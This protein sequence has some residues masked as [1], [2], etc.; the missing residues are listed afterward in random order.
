MDRSLKAALLLNASFE[1]RAGR[2][3]DRWIR[4]GRDPGDLMAFSGDWTDLGLPR[5]AGETLARGVARGWAE[6]ELQRCLRLGVRLLPWGD[7]GLPEGLADLPDPPGVLYLW[8]EG[9][10]PPEDRA[11]GAVGTRRATAYG[12]R[13]AR[14]LGERAAETGMWLVSGG[15]D[16]VDGEA[17]R[18]S[19]EAGGPTLAVLG[20]GVDRVFPAAHR[21]LFEQIRKEGCLVSEYPLG[22]EGRPWR[23]PLRNRLLA[24]LTG[25]LAVVEAPMR[26]GALSTARRALELGRE[27]WAV[28]GRVDEDTCR[29]SNRLLFDGAFPLVDLEDFLPRK[30]QGIL[31][32]SAPA[33]S[34]SEGLGEAA[35]RV[36]G[37]L[38]LEGDRT[39]DNLAAEGRMSAADV[40][41]VLS[42]LQA[43][44][45]V[46]PS[47]PGRFRAAPEGRPRTP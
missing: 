15:A 20:T 27:V 23:F 24:A 31:F 4:Q 37:L 16:G 6:E 11:V 7:P 44:G 2:A 26:S 19:L 13:V 36:L 43:S 9:A 12:R 25:R 22:T 39:V 30:G 35:A 28:P 21:E 3:L 46:Y 17:H 14:A 10:L 33:P 29:G 47:G 34:L 32:P 41:K 45:R 42:V 5:E 40:L 18:G 1:G 8:G 38:A